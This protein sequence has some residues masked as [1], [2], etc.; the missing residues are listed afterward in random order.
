ML[1]LTP[2]HMSALGLVFH[3]SSPLDGLQ[4]SEYHWVFGVLQLDLYYAP[5]VNEFFSPILS[6]V[7]S[8]FLYNTWVR[9]ASE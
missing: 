3:L 8:G 6:E 4:S 1:F 2:S 7:E 5:G 9:I